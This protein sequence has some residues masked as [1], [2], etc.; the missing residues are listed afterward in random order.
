MN[1]NEVLPLPNNGLLSGR[2]T[3]SGQKQPNFATTPSS[4]P[5]E[6]HTS[7]TMQY[8]WWP[9]DSMTHPLSRPLLQMPSL[10]KQL[11][12]HSI[13]SVVELSMLSICLGFSSQRCKQSGPWQH[14]AP[15]MT[16]CTFIVLVLRGQLLEERMQIQEYCVHN[17]W[18]L[19]LWA[20]CKHQ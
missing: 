17:L 15:F 16:F 2:V 3:V 20:G 19:P 4:V 13:S 9:N 18:L 1:I 7:V 8:A 6:T 12:L 11:L 14:L 5:V 10:L